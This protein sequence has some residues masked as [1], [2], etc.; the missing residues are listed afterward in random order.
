MPEHKRIV[1]YQDRTIEEFGIPLTLWTSQIAV[2]HGVPKT[3]AGAHANMNHRY[4][5]HAVKAGNKPNQILGQSFNLGNTS[6]EDAIC[7]G[8]NPFPSD[9]RQ[10]VNQYFL[11][12]FAGIHDHSEAVMSDINEEPLLSFVNSLIDWSAKD[13]KTGINAFIKRISGN[14]RVYSTSTIASMLW[15]AAYSLESAIVREKEFDLVQDLIERSKDLLEKLGKDIYQRIAFP[16]SKE[17]L[18]FIDGIAKQKNAEEYVKASKCKMAE[19]MMLLKPLRPVGKMVGYAPRWAGAKDISEFV[20][21]QE[22]IGLK[23]PIDSIYM[24][25]EAQDIELAGRSFL[26]NQVVK[27]KGLHRKKGDVPVAIGKA[28]LVDGKYR[29]TLIPSGQVVVAKPADVEQAR[30]QDKESM[31]RGYTKDGTW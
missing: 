6:H 3:A 25:D 28:D 8:T 10:A 23:G 29:I 19:L 13:A 27:D 20:M 26:S 2:F 5:V 21:G 22:Y 15:C 24:S 17:E 11:S 4:L 1:V 31:Y 9:L 18:S 12:S 14:V 16:L 7:W 30:P